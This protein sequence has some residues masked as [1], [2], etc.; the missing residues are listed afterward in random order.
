L[1]KDYGAY[2]NYRNFPLDI[3]GLK[4]VER[5][6][7]LSAYKIARGKFVK[8]R[9]VDAYTIGHYHPHGECYGSIVQLVRQG[10]LIG[11]GNFGTNVG[12]EPVGPAA[13]RYTECQIHPK[14]TEMAFKYIDD[15]PWVDSELGDREPIYLPTMFPI[16]LMGTDY[17]QGIGFGYKTYIPCFTVK[18][19]YQRL[20]WL[21]GIRKSKPIIA[22]M[23]DCKILSDKA[24]LD[25]L[26]T[27][28]KAKVHV[29]GIVEINPKAN[30][31]TL[32]S[33]P[34]GKRFESF[35]NKFSKELS[36][37]LIGFTDLSVTE[38]NIV[39][40]VIRERNRDKIFEQFLEKLKEVIQGYISFEIVVVDS[41]QNVLTKSID[42]MLLDTYNMFSQTNENMLKSEIV[43]IDNIINEYNNLAIIRPIIVAGISA[44]KDIETITDEI[45]KNTSVSKQ[46]AKELIS[47]YRISKLITIDTDTSELINKKVEINNNLKDLSTFVMN[48][49]N[50]CIGKL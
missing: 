23:T 25:K 33:W 42:Q 6:V 18:D 24:L 46:T 8:S 50:E 31:A 43:K 35:L 22:P 34:P 29:E 16:C 3:D 37:G 45:E 19:L 26:L 15:V 2:S 7:L 1:Y 11:Q 9:Q 32:K 27:T 14:T 39:F 13:P 4:P 38:T 17:T 10:F 20:L 49:Y 30:T 41:N 5:R 21:L 40:Q 28:G 48:Q 47:K 12:V 44:K 36:E